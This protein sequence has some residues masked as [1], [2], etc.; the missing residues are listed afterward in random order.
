MNKKIFYIG[1]TLCAILI[2]IFTY[3]FIKNKMIT[4]SIA[5]SFEQYKKQCN[6]T[7]TSETEKITTYT[8]SFY[9]FSFTIPDDYV[10]CE[11]GSESKDR[12]NLHIMPRTMFMSQDIVFS[13]DGAFKIMTDSLLVQ[14]T[15]GAIEGLPQLAIKERL[16]SKIIGGIE[17]DTAVA[18]LPK[19]TKK[20]CPEI[21]VYRFLRN[22]FQYEFSAAKP[23]DAVFNSFVFLPKK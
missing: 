6:K 13:K 21:T 23:F 19:C 11:I 4:E 20:S 15:K 1:I 10:V 2:A 3:S 7:L 8:N 22:G 5:N 16:P 17:A 18:D 14:I 9:G 12:F